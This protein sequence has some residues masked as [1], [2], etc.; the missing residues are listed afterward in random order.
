M[1]DVINEVAIIVVSLLSVA[2]ASM[3]YSPV[4]FG[5]IWMKEAGLSESEYDYDTAKVT[6]L[7]FVSFVVNILLFSVIAK[8]FSVTQEAGVSGIHLIFFIMVAVG[9]TMISPVIWEKKSLTYFFINF[10]YTTFV[11]VGGSSILVY[12]P[13]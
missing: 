5:K 10:C 4:F 11:I 8:M 6:K 13:W 2:V 1:F 7:F 9:A 12:W 3:W